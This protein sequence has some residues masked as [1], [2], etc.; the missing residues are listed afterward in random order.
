MISGCLVYTPAN[1]CLSCSKGY[2][3]NN[4]SCF[5]NDTN[6]VS[7]D[8]NGL[9]QQCLNGFL[10]YKSSC[11]YFDPYCLAYDENRVCSQSS[12]AFSLGGFTL[13]QQLSYNNVIMQAAQGGSSSNSNNGILSSLPY[14][15]ISSSSIASYD[16]NGNIL[17]CKTGLSL[18]NAQ[19]VI[20]DGNCMSYNQYNTCQQCNPGFDLL[21]NNTCTARSSATCARQAGGICL[22]AA[23]GYTLIGGG[24]YFSGNNIKQAGAN[25]Q[26]V[27]AAGGYFVWTGNNIAWPYDFNCVLQTQPGRCMQCAS[28]LFAINN[29]RCVLIKNNC[30]AYSP[31]GLCM[32]CQAGFILWVGE[33]RRANCNGFDTNSGLCKACVANYTLSLGFCAPRPISNCQLYSGTSCS[34][35][36]TGFYRTGGGLCARTINFCQ[37]AS[38]QTGRCSQCLY[39]YTIYQEQCIPQIQNCQVYT[40]SLNA[41]SSCSSSLYYPISNGTQCG[42]LG[43]YCATLNDTGSCVACNPGLTLTVQN[44]TNIC[45]RPI[46][47][48]FSYDASIKCVVCN[49]NYVL[50]YNKCKS[51]RCNNYNNTLNQCTVC[52]PPFM[53]TNGTCQ[54]PN[55]A[56]NII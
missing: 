50:Q 7:Q 18:L 33:C 44:G 25:G 3:L 15:G 12:S 41:C 48:C 22:Q 43:F 19:C 51:I 27:S 4:G 17:T 24:A 13:P 6:C 1:T 54:D 8:S 37:T 40:A 5:F 23:N 42:Y 21:P 55:C 10:P 39:G 35:C 53:L 20:S 14:A 38:P 47:N 9:C 32:G 30:L 11:V 26:I 52:T 31:Y 2:L 29:G 46:P 45:I 56:K 16:M 34:A 49:S 28:S 36:Q